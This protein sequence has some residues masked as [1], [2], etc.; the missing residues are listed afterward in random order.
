MT[1][2]SWGRFDPNE[3]PDSAVLEGYRITRGEVR[4]L[5]EDEKFFIA[6]NFG[7]VSGRLLKELFEYFS[8]KE[9]G[10]LS[11]ADIE[12]QCSIEDRLEY[13]PDSAIA[14]DIKALITLGGWSP[15]TK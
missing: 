3:C 11:D 6:S 15:L 1:A 8:G 13:F 4:C 7:F 5:E 12:I 9:I 14:S 10:L 2:S